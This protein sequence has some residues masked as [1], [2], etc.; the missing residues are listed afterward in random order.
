MQSTNGITPLHPA[1]GE[2]AAALKH[3][4]E[5]LQPLVNAAY[6]ANAAYVVELDVELEEAHIKLDSLLL[7]MEEDGPYLGENPLDDPIGRDLTD[8]EIGY[9]VALARIYA[10]LYVTP[11]YIKEY[12]DEDKRDYLAGQV[13]DLADDF[14]GLRDGVTPDQML[15]ACK[16]AFDLNQHRRTP[17]KP[18][19]RGIGIEPLQWLIQ[20]GANYARS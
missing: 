5:E 2:Q 15:E 3:R 19:L 13:S 1:F 20:A 16:E 6:A 17:H 18:K 9:D 12:D 11:G 8:A 14:G 4:I 7:Q 10:T